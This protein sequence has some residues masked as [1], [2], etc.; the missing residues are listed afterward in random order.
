[1]HDRPPVSGKLVYAPR[2]TRHELVSLFSDR[3]VLDR[4][5]TEAKLTA[6]RLLASTYCR[7]PEQLPYA[8]VASLVAV[9]A[10]AP[11]LLRSL[12]DSE[13]TCAL[14]VMTADGC[15]ALRAATVET[16]VALIAGYSR[17]RSWLKNAPPP[18]VSSFL[19]FVAADYCPA[20]GNINIILSRLS[21]PALLGLS[22]EL[23]DAATCRAAPAP[24]LAATVGALLRPESLSAFPV[25][26]LDSLLAVIGSCPPLVTALPAAK[27]AVLLDAV[28]KTP[29]ALESVNRGHL[30]NVLDAVSSVETLAYCV[31]LTAWRVLLRSCR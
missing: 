27:I 15:A 4:L 24:A 19:A 23:S 9:C 7:R 16:A 18:T 11:D 17:T 20:N 5:K 28:T 31:P 12:T 26:D 2:T 6:V 14:T 22:A 8:A 10:S 21:P 30:V 3:A 1:M 25:R 13:R 29:A